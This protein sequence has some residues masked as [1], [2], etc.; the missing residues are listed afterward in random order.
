M[1][2]RRDFD[3]LTPAQHVQ[4]GAAERA[5]AIASRHPG[6]RTGSDG[7]DGATRTSQVGTG[8]HIRLG[9]SGRGSVLLT[10]QPA[11]VSSLSSVAAQ[12][13]RYWVR[14]FGRVF[15]FPVANGGIMI[16]DGP[17]SSPWRAQRAIF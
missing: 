14:H 7:S 4:G 11:P 16:F 6:E 10:S 3:R 1:R 17:W 8:K 2:A 12:K 13:V 5:G 9:N 15:T